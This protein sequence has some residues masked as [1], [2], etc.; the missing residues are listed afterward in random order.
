MQ[1]NLKPPYNG[2]AQDKFFWDNGECAYMEDISNEQMRYATL[3]MTYALISGGNTGTTTNVNQLSDTPAWLITCWDSKV[4]LNGGDVSATV[5]G[6]KRFEYIFD[7]SGN[8]VNYFMDSTN[9]YEANTAIS[10]LLRAAV[11]HAA[12][13]WT[14]TASCLV[15]NEI[16]CAKGSTILKYDTVTHASTSLASSIP[17]LTGSTVKYMYFYND[18]VYIVTVRG[19]DTIIYLVQYS[20][21]GYWIYSKEEIKG[22]V[23]VWAVG[24]GSIVYWITTNKIYAFSGATSQLVR[25]IWTNNSFDEATFSSTPS[26]AYDKGFL[27]IASGNSIWKYGSKY[28]GRRASFTKKTFWETILGITGRYI[29]TQNTTNYIYT[30]SSKYPNS[31]NYL[32]LPFD[33]GDYSEVKDNLRFRVWY[34]LRT[35][36]SLTIGVMTDA[37]EM[38]N[39]T[40]Y[41]TVATISDTSKRVSYISV[42][43]ITAALGSNSPEWQYLRFKVTL[44]WGWWSSGA[45]DN[46]PSIYDI[47]AVYEPTQNNL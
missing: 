36:T 34:Q 43:E 32:S 3:A 47:T 30:D 46:T 14:V 20:S 2:I 11:A 4:L 22:E 39:T 10:A 6:A 17:I 19:Y 8:Q 16:L 26:L 25:Y 37:M 40:T 23:C 33:A 13:T 44:T 21:S 29:E 1:F 28:Q 27:Y 41:A 24:N 42:Q 45:R 38:A 15:Y 31:G 18:M 35:G 7:A 5:A 9:T 12:G